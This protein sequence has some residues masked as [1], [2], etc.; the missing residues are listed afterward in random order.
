M[1]VLT[2]PPGTCALAATSQFAFHLHSKTLSLQPRTAAH[3]T[4]PGSMGD[5]QAPS[6][7]SA[8]PI[9][10]RLRLPINRWANC[11]THSRCIKSTL[12][13]L[14][15]ASVRVLARTLSTHHALAPNPEVTLGR[16]DSGMRFTPHSHNTHSAS[17][18]GIAATCP[19]VGVRMALCL[20][21]G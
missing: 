21:M 7:A 3:A 17:S 12:R 11:S 1:R 20:K 10:K 5:E 4:Y 2:V 16:K 14:T 18:G 6:G 13:M 15:D 19:R 9:V 8:H